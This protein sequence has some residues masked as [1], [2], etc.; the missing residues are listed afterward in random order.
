[1][2]TSLAHLQVNIDPA[3]AAFYKDMLGFL[4]WQTLY[5]GDGMLGLGAAN[6]ASLWFVGGL[7][8]VTNDYDGPGTNHI[9]IGAQSVADVDAAAAYLKEQG[10]S[11]LF[12]TPR[13]RPEFSDENSTYYQVMFESP[14]RV[15]F[16]IVYTGPK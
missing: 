16:E 5:E 9:G 15:L 10:I 1:M 12:E 7:K 11:A 13:H 2:Q 6:E 14:D 4:G 3:N 8:D